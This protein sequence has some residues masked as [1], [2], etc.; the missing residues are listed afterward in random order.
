MISHYNLYFSIVE[1]RKE[2]A[3]VNSSPYKISSVS[4]SFGFIYFKYKW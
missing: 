4:L 2:T 3:H 1:I